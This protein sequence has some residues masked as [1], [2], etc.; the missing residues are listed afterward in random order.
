MPNTCPAQCGGLRPLCPGPAQSQ[1]EPHRL[2]SVKC[3]LTSC[4]HTSTHTCAHA[5]L[6][7][8]GRLQFP[9]TF[10]NGQFLSP[11]SGMGQSWGLGELH[12]GGSF[13]RGWLVWSPY[14]KA[15]DPERSGWMCMIPQPDAG[16]GPG[17]TLGHTEST[18]CSSAKRILP[19]LCLHTDYSPRDLKYILFI[20]PFLSTPEAESE[21]SPG[22]L[23]GRDGHEGAPPT[24]PW[25]HL[26]W[27]CSVAEVP[28]IWS[29]PILQ[30]GGVTLHGYT[31]HV[32]K[33]K[34]WF[35]PS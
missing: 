34:I 2:G 11:Q 24:G 10:S 25:S 16:E 17:Q 21:V 31:V 12:F 27:P 1:P 30:S 5:C 4:A 23:P 6:C 28:H 19:A 20:L 8:G 13:Q 18:F 7:L 14:E 29:A 33:M 15:C 26:A 35:S 3:V 32:S 22:T 9:C